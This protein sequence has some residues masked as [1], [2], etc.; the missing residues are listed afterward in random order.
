M[1]VAFQSVRLTCRTRKWFDGG[2]A[3]LG[4]SHH[5]Q[6]RQSPLRCRELIRLDAEAMQHRE[7]KVAERV[8][9]LLVEGQMLAVLETAAGEEDR[10]IHVRV[11]VRAS[12]AGAVQDHRAVEQRLPFFFRFIE[13][14]DECVERVE[15][16]FFVTA[17]FT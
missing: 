10:E 9:V 3:H 6:S 14:R 13:R 11:R 16:L 5:F 17:Q 8:V 1:F 4:N 2:G 15:L 7:I 12:H